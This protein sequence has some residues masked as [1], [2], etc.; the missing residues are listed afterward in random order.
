MGRGN[1]FCWGQYEK[2]TFHV[3]DGVSVDEAMKRTKVLAIGAHADDLELMAAPAI[4][5]AYT[6]DPYTFTGIVLTDGRSSPKTG[7]YAECT[8]EQ[9]IRLRQEEQMRAADIGRYSAVIMLNME[10]KDVKDSEGRGSEA[11]YPLIAAATGS[12]TIWTH[13]VLDRHPTHLATALRTV[14]AIRRLSSDQRPERIWGGEVW[15]ALDCLPDVCRFPLDRPNVL[16]ALLGVYDSQISGGKRYDLAAFGRWQ[17]N[18]T[19]GESH[20]I[21][22]ASLVALALDMSSLIYGLSVSSLID[23]LIGNYRQNAADLLLSVASRTVPEP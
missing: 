14:E 12:R 23:D 20:E 2:A 18:A 15:G 7:P 22:K 13:N 21:D 5:Q 3:P 11:L 19:F 1:Q 16:A 8:T 17:A 4:M 10:S 6:G 9:M